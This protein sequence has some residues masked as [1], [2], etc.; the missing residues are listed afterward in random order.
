M[1]LCGCVAINVPVFGIFL[2][3]V[4]R[5]LWPVRTDH[6]EVLGKP[7]QKGGFCKSEMRVKRFGLSGN[8]AGEMGRNNLGVCLFPLLFFIV[9]FAFYGVYIIPKWLIKVPRH[10]PILFG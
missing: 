10:I 2:L 1:W 8:P 3:F 7:G 5:L 9:F 4:V 6:T